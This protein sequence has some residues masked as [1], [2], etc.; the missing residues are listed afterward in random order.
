VL[1]GRIQTKET[2]RIQRASSL[3]RG[4]AFSSRFP[5]MVIKFYE[6]HIIWARDPKDEKKHFEDS[7]VS[8]ESG[9]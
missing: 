4:E 9:D 8:G 6:A 1:S 7:N 2:E 5:D 3:V